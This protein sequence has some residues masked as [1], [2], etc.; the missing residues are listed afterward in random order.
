[1]RNDGESLPY[2]IVYKLMNYCSVEHTIGVLPSI[3]VELSYY[4]SSLP[5]AN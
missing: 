5:R 3:R 1:M 4:P 2:N